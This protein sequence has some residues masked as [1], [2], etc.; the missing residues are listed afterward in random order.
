M[1][2]IAVSLTFIAASLTLAAQPKYVVTD[3]GTL[4]GTGSTTPNT[5]NN[6]GQVTGRSSTSSGESHAFRTAPNSVIATSDNL[7]TLG[8]SSST[9]NAINDAGQVA[10]SSSTT[11]TTPTHAFRS[12]ANFGTGALTDLGT[13]DGTFNILVN[14]CRSAEGWAINDSGVVVGD[15]ATNL[16]SGIPNHAFRATPGSGMTN[17]QPAVFI[18]SNAHGINNTGQIVGSVTNG[19]G[20]T[21]CYRTVPGENITFFRDDLG[22]LGAAFCQAQSVNNAGDV[23]GILPRVPPSTRF[24]TPTERCMTSTA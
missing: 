7:G 15:S 9:G 6:L 8:G 4:G 20:Q 12:S 17:I 24:C 11:G 1:Q 14:N 21:L 2:K 3:L 18:S 22:N 10:G 13:F 19:I 5:I 23:W 16:F